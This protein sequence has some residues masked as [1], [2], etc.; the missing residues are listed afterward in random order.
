MNLVLMVLF[1]L[2]RSISVLVFF[3]DRIR[4]VDLGVLL[5]LGE[6][7][8][9]LRDP[10]RV[11][12]KGLSSVGSAASSSPVLGSAAPW[13][14]EKC[15]LGQREEGSA[16]SP[17]RTGFSRRERIRIGRASPASLAPLER[18]LGRSPPRL[19][20]RVRQFLDRERIA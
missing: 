11:G 2:I 17:A 19:R 14:R 5:P 1:S 6:H 9:E 18:L 7:E 4:R 8:M 3:F 16:E 12:R 15:M 13:N 10:S 20:S